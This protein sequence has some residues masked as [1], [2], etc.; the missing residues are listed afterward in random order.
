MVYGE[1]DAFGYGQESERFD[2]HLIVIDSLDAYM[3]L[4]PNEPVY[5]A[6]FFQQNLLLFI[7]HYD[8]MWRDPQ[9]LFELSDVVVWNNRISPILVICD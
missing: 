3:A 4:S 8:P 6:V 9:G 2:T 5:D 7:Y 1:D